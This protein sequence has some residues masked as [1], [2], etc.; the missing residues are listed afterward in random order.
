MGLDRV[1]YI[2]PFITL[3]VLNIGAICRASE[4]SND[5]PSCNFYTAK[6]IVSGKRYHVGIPSVEDLTATVS[7]L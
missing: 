6:Q 1:L 3:L 4:S 2:A 7:L 5:V